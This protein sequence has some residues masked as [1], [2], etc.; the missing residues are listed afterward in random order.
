MRKLTEDKGR[1]GTDRKTEKEAEATSRR[2]RERSKV[3]VAMG[4]MVR[5]AE[6]GATKKHVK[7]I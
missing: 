4:G 6:K 3:A 5:T 7:E 2:R 1:A